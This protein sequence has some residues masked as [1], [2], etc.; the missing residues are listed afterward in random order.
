[1]RSIELFETTEAAP[2]MPRFSR[3][4]KMEIIKTILSTGRPTQFRELARVKGCL[5][6]KIYALPE[7]IEQAY[8]NLRIELITHY[9]TVYNSMAEIDR[10]LLNKIVQTNKRTIFLPDTAPYYKR[11]SIYR[12]SRA[13]EALRKEWKCHYEIAAKEAQLLAESIA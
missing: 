9:S 7:E 12:I 11:T 3:R 8:F 13:I 6:T 10:D 2:R 5:E 1:M 4:I